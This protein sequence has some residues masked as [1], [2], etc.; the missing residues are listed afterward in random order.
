MCYSFVGTIDLFYMYSFYIRD[1]PDLL[2]SKTES[3]N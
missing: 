1:G 3:I 2:R